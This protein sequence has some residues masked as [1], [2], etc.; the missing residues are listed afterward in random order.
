MRSLGA[1]ILIFSFVL[2]SFADTLK[3]VISDPNL[4]KSIFYNSGDQV[5][6]RHGTEGYSFEY[7]LFDARW[8]DRP[9]SAF[10][11]LDS[12]ECSDVQYYG[13]TLYAVKNNGEMGQDLLIYNVSNPAKPI[14]LQSLTGVDSLPHLTENWAI[15]PL[16]SGDYAV[17]RRDAEGRL[18]D[19]RVQSISLPLEPV[20]YP[21]DENTFLSY[22][23]G[24]LPIELTI[25]EDGEIATRMIPLGFPP[26]I[27]YSACLPVIT[28]FTRI[29]DE[30]LVSNCLLCVDG[31]PPDN[32]QPDKV[33]VP[34][35]WKPPLGAIVFVEGIRDATPKITMPDVNLNPDRYQ[36]PSF[37]SVENAAVYRDYL[38]V[39]QWQELRIWK[40]AGDT[41]ELVQRTEKPTYYYLAISGHWLLVSGF[42]SLDIYD[43]SQLSTNVDRWVLY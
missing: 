34:I 43:L 39:I 42:S 10:Y 35:N 14:L 22:A 17:Y 7:F 9:G 41:M 15:R 19:V 40:R 18:T 8:D 5:V 3:P 6:I 4:R 13:E 33:D 29:G 2:S 24:N 37:E 30:L 16:S 12:L 23:Y 32:F 25:A 21:W 26:F 1:V 27:G 38:A 31:T 11:P 20:F 28:G 36:D